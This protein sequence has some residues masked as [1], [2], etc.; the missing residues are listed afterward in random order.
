MTPRDLDKALADLAQGGFALESHPMLGV[1]LTAA[2]ESLSA[3]ELASDLAVARVGR[4]VVSVAEAD[5]TNDLAWHTADQGRDAADG[6]AVFAEHQAQGRGR[7]G[8][9]WIAPPH[10]SILCSVLLWC[11]ARGAEAAILTRAAAVAAAHAVRDQTRLD[12]GI[13]WPND[14]VVDDRKVGGILVEVR[15]GAGESPA[16]VG[17]GLNCSQDAA[18]FPPAF[19]ARAASLAMFGASVDRTLLARAL[20]EQLDH[21]LGVA[22]DRPDE[23]RRAAAA[24]CRTLGTEVTL[25]EG[26]STF[27]GT[28]ADL[29]ADYGLVLRLADGSLRRFWAFTTH[30]T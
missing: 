12:A 30:V 29:D 24:L 8:T 11:P 7:R 19:R 18:A 16:V 1:R 23:V 15:G 3:E 20:L 21:W 2:P 25:V 13:K 14:I 5:S 27:H 17:I 9:R 26:A 6:F 4:R 10:S 28:V 22:A